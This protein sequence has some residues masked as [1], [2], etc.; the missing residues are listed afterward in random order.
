MRDRAFESLQEEYRE[1]FK[2]YN[3]AL[4]LLGK[5]AEYATDTEDER[6]DDMLADGLASLLE[7]TLERCMENLRRLERKR[8]NDIR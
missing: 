3:K 7:S 5:V 8:R 6:L 4:E 1:L 2:R